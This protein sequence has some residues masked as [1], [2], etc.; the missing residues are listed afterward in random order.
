MYCL[1]LIFFLENIYLHLYFDFFKILNIFNADKA[2][3]C[4]YES[5]FRIIWFD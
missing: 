3:S 1:L 2:K 4:T 5:Y